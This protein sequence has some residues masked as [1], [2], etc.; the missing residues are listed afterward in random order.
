MSARVFV[1]LSVVV[2][3]TALSASSPAQSTTSLATPIAAGTRVRVSAVQLG[4]AITGVVVTHSADTLVVKADGDSGTIALPTAQMAR[5]EIS[6]GKH[7]QKLKGAR[8]GYLSGAALGAMAGYATYEDPHCRAEDWICIDFGPGFDAA[9]G[10]TFLGA[11]GALVG[12]LVGN[13]EREQWRPASGGLGRDARM[14][15]A[16]ARGGVALTASLTF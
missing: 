10:A 16:P 13:H 14:G 6:R 11:V 7:T 1:S 8:I 5:L 9:V 3:L 12:T 2:A 15:I 4:D